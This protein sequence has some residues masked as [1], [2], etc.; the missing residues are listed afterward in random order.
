MYLQFWCDANS[1]EHFDAHLKVLM[2]AYGHGKTLGKGSGKLLLK[3]LIA[4]DLLMS[5]HGLFK[6]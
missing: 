2:E 3:P 4:R 5:Q 6:I 1:E